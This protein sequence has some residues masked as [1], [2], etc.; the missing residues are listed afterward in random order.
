[1]YNFQIKTSFVNLN[2]LARNPGSAPAS[3]IYFIYMGPIWNLVALPI[4]VPYGL[5]AGS[6]F[7]FNSLKIGLF[8]IFRPS[9]FLF[10]IFWAHYSLFIIKK[11]HYSLFIIKKG[12]YSL[13]I[14][15]HPDSHVDVETPL[16]VD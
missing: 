3:T 15:P 16:S 13:F 6:L 10:I 2:P 8:I 7:F 14:I 5:L 1:M 4:W 11:G 9:I 12:H